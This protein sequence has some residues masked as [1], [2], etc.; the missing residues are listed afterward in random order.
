MLTTP[1]DVHENRPNNLPYTC[2]TA[3]SSSLHLRAR[4]LPCT[5]LQSLH[6]EYTAHGRPNGGMA[7]M[8]YITDGLIT[9]SWPTAAV[10]SHAYIRQ[11]TS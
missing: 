5:P 7:L 4:V 10:V 2:R 3:G 11:H 1:I 6:M 8:Y 9:A